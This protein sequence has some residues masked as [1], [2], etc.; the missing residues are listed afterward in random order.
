MHDVWIK[1]SPR[2]S[3]M[4]QYSGRI[5]SIVPRHRAELA[6]IAAK[7]E[8]ETANRAKSEFL[9]HISHEL[10]T[11]LNAIIGFS[12]VIRQDLLGAGSIDRYRDYAGDIFSSGEHLLS[13]INDILDLTKHDVGRVELDCEFIELPPIID[14]CAGLLRESANS[15]KQTLIINVEDDLPPVFADRKRIKQILINLASNAVKFTPDGGT[16][17]ISATMNDSGRLVIEVADTGVGMAQQEIAVA[18]EPFRQVEHYLTRQHDGTGLGLPIAKAFSDLHGA[19]FI[20]VS[21]QGKGTSIS[22]EFPKERLEDPTNEAESQSNVTRE[23]A[24]LL[25]AIPK[26]EEV[27]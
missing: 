6:L 21:E 10:R 8:A 16:V 18:L 19:N 7:N 20:V 5:G 14:E 4:D 12:D 22:L 13:I 17:T 3:L 24:R 1:S 27:N 25:E 11:P 26:T 2:Q 23:A 9:A 15:Q